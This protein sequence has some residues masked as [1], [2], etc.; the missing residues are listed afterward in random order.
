M[1]RPHPRPAIAAL[2]LLV[3]GCGIFGLDDERDRERERLE[4]AA[5]LW[6]NSAPS[7]YRFVLERS[8]FCIMEVTAPVRIV[9]EDGAVVSR[10]YVESGEPVPSEW[11]PQFPA[12]EGVFTVLRQAMDQ[13]AA[14]VQVSY[15]PQLGFPVDAFIDYL[16]AAID[17]ELTLRVRDFTPE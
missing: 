10:T 14:T 13:D 15:D 17:D 11:H 2:P 6:A 5:R 16:A 3:V 4:R 12:M 9:V 1:Y 8:C 7:S